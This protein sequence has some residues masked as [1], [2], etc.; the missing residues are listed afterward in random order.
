MLEGGGGRLKK[1]GKTLE[2]I[3][4]IKLAGGQKPAALFPGQ[5]WTGIS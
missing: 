1:S 4:I 2:K 3:K 5:D